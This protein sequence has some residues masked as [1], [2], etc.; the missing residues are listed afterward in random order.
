VNYHYRSTA[1]GAGRH[2]QRGRRAAALLLQVV[3]LHGAQQQLQLICLHFAAGFT[4]GWTKRFE[5]SYNK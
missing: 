3:P 4:T 5:Y 1:A 2:Q